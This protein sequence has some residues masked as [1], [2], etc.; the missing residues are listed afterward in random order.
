MAQRSRLVSFALLLIP[1]ILLFSFRILS[2]ELN[3]ALSNDTFGQTI[4]HSLALLIG[5]ILSYR[6]SVVHDHEFLRSKAI[7]DLSKT[8]K[9]EDRG[10]WEK[11][12]VAIQRL[13]ARAFSEF[14]GRRASASRRRMQGMI[15]E[16]NRESQE[17]EQKMSDDS[18]Y[19]VAVDG[20]EQKENAEEKQQEK[21]NSTSRFSNF[22][23][24]TIE[25]SAK[26]REERRKKLASH[27]S[28]STLP[29]EDNN[30]STWAVPVGTQR[31]VRFCEICSTYNDE[32]SNYCSSC[33]SYIT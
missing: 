19:S 32:E 14:K 29:F 17:I 4:A 23:S 9:L 24:S 18:D 25:K 21:T 2:P 8:Y 22:I 20:I 7:G 3:E 13:E 15:G 16:I 27:K 30:N 5:L 33:G 10:L 26:R 1:N 12:E 31:K 6:N 11:G 28:K